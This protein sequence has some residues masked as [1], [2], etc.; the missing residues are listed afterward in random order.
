[1]TVIGVLKEVQMIVSVMRCVNLNN[2]TLKVLG[3]HFSHN[4]KLKEGKK[5][6]TI[7]TNIQR[8]LKVW[9][10]RNLTLEDK[11]VVLKTLAIS[12]I[13][14]Q[15]LITTIPRHI[16]NELEKIQKALL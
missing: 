5:F 3:I 14:F 9:K 6:Y 8:V 4:G 12:K 15:F 13:V 11:I 7:A 16:I 1:M 10:I 2:D